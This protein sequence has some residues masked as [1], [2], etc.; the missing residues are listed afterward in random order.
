MIFTPLSKDLASICDV[1]FSSVGPGL[2]PVPSANIPRIEI[3]FVCVDGGLWMRCGQM[4][5]RL[6]NPR[7][8]KN[9]VQFEDWISSYLY[10]I[11]S[12]LIAIVEMY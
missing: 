12:Y 3:V 11:Y 8:V 4:N 1:S 2:S 5:Q 9:N 10:H 6:A 7:C